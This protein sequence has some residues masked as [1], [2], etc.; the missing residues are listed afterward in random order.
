MFEN[1]L[2]IF[3]RDYRIV[4]NIGLS[5]ANSK[6]KNLYTIFIFTPEQ[7]G[8]SNSYKS[9]NAVQFMIESLMDLEDAIAKEGGK[10]Y[11][12][13]G[14]NK[15]IIEKC[16]KEFKIDF[17]CFNKDYTPYA[18]ERDNEIDLQCKKANIFL[19]MGHDYYLTEPGTITSG[20]KEPYKKFTPYYEHALKKGIKPPLR[21]HALKLAVKRVSIENQ[22]S[23]KDAMKKF[24]KLNPNLLIHGGR[25]K[26]IQCLKH[27][28]ERQKNYSKYHNELTYKTTELSAYIKFGCLSI[29]EMATAFKSNHD[30]LR[31]IYWREF[32]ATILYAFPY[33]LRNPM[34]LAYKK[35]KWHKNDRYLNAWKEGKTGIPVVDAGMRQMNV[36]GYMHNRAR[37]IV[38]SFLVKTLLINWREGEHYFATKL[39]D[40]DVASNNGNWQWVAGTGA[41]SMPYFRI[42][43]PWRQAEE[44]DPDCKYIKTWIPE[45]RDVP[46]KDIF[47]WSKKWYEYKNT[48]YPKPIIDFKKQTEE[49]MKMYQ[50]VYK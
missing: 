50:A 25:E 11:I 43:N 31:Q 42:F 33:V 41:D 3:R 17:I 27:S 26:A 21:K 37:L 36:T 49:A 6:C 29:R 44:M 9:D 35:I 5:I 40:Y 1:G 4:D 15:S 39:T 7:V 28:I 34:K 2:F 45:L 10:L 38:A 14:K 24:T 30:L 12:F 20:S 46:E 8:K 19:E 32:Y 22:I 23:L 18:I 16:I 48:K 13:Y 47:N